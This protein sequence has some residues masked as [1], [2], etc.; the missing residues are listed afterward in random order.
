[1]RHHRYSRCAF[2]G[3]AASRPT[4]GSSSSFWYSTFSVVV[5]GEGVC[6]C[7]FRWAAVAGAVAALV[8]AA[9]SAVAGLVVLGEAEGLVVAALRGVG[10][11]KTAA[12]NINN[13]FPSFARE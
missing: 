7:S 11:P 10:S 13:R 2:V 5:G 6:R 8:A 12:V 9:G 3:D 1:M 4:S